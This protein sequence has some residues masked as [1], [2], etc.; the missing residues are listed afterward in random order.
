MGS[1]GLFAKQL[2]LLKQRGVRILHLPPMS[3]LDNLYTTLNAVHQ[4]IG[5]LVEFDNSINPIGQFIVKEIDVKVKLV[6][7]GYKIT[8]IRYSP[9]DNLN[10]SFSWT[11]CKV[12]EPSN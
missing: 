5:K 12:I 7:D 11:H 6:D 3:S 4:N 8:D 10:S 1:S 2:R 9:K